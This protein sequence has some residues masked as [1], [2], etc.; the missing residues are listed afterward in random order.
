MPIAPSIAP[1]RAAGPARGSRALPSLNAAASWDTLT[2]PERE[3]W[4]TLEHAAIEVCGPAESWAVFGGSLIHQAKAD[5]TAARRRYVRHRE[6][7]P[8]APCTCG[9][10]GLLEETL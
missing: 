6:G 1:S 9:L 10:G 7:C 2:E 3:A 4:R 8:K 5:T